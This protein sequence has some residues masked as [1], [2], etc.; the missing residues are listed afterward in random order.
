MYR[1]ELLH[2]HWRDGAW[3]EES[4]ATNEVH[5]SEAGSAPPLRPGGV[6]ARELGD[7][8]PSQVGNTEL[9]DATRLYDFAFRGEI[10]RAW[11]E[12]AQASSGVGPP[13]GRR[14]ILDID[15]G[16]LRR[17]HWERMSNGNGLDRPGAEPKGSLV[18][19]P[20]V[21]DFVDS[22][23][24]DALKILIVVGSRPQDPAVKAEEE[25]AALEETFGP[26]WRK[27]E[28]VVLRQPSRGQVSDALQSRPDVF[29]F[30]GHG[31]LDANR[32]PFLD[33]F[34]A[35]NQPPLRWQLQDILTD[36]GGIAPA[37]VFLNACHTVDQTDLVGAASMT[38][39]FLDNIGA[40]AVLGMHAA[41]R[42]TT[43]GKLAGE[44]YEALANGESLDLALTRARNKADVLKSNDPAREWDWSL[45]YLRLSVLPEQVLPIARSVPK[46]LEKEIDLVPCFKPN[47]YFVDRV[48]PH[49]ELLRHVQPDPN[50][51]SNMLLITGP[52][53]VGKSQLI[54]SCLEIAARRGRLVKYVEL[55]PAV[56]LDLLGFLRLICEGDVWSPIAGPLPRQAMKRFYQTLNTLLQG[57][58]PRD[59]GVIEAQSEIVKWG[60]LPVNGVEDQLEHI[61]GSFTQ[62]L[63]DVPAKARVE[64]AEKLEGLGLHDQAELCRRDRRPFLLVLDQLA[65]RDP[66]WASAP[67]AWNVDRR[68][69]TD[70]LVPHLI[71][72]IAAGA[73]PEVVL[74]VGVTES[75]VSAFGLDARSLRLSPTT[76]PVDALAPA[77]F[78]ELALEYCTKRKIE[79]A[80]RGRNGDPTSWRDFVTLVGAM[81][82]TTWR[83]GDLAALYDIVFSSL[84]E[85]P[86]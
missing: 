67:S 37:F 38:D 21:F 53:E 48:T 40:R 45:P 76:I 30:I 13:E 73:V 20:V 64:R 58:D 5:P 52:R 12:S 81:R 1:V 85:A 18:R 75:A 69:F 6:G 72:P 2:A 23:R 49:R 26:L 15:P 65:V 44:L 56:P 14:L 42:G 51:Q 66:A 79:E 78:G 47:E 41:V 74:L 7:G 68:L 16:D 33:L 22:V 77:N 46:S 39:L 84:V 59:P 4:L 10:L 28:C 34:Q 11:R 54:R 9:Q 43:A 70:H 83:P 62:A 60:P 24:D 27:V 3:Q 31:N 17:R 61:F 50:R 86:Q 35:E 57:K 36:F 8:Q 55:D 82:R 29:H 71:R 32:Q 19:G 25:V 63:R 80:I